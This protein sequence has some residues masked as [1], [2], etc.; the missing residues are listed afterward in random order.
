MKV[1]WRVALVLVAVGAALVPMPSALIERFYSGGLY[2]ILQPHVTTASKQRVAGT[3][4][5]ITDGQLT[6][7]RRLIGMAIGLYRGP[8]ADIDCAVG[9]ARWISVICPH[10]A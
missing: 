1:R 7:I 8:P 2:L 4:S 10:E 6:E 9:K 3:P 5:R